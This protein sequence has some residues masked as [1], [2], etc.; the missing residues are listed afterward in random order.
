M[1]NLQASSQRQLRAFVDQLENIQGEMKDLADTF[2]EKMDE[3]KSTGFDVKIIRKILALKK[4]SKAQRDEE[5]A[6]MAVYMSALG[7]IGTPLGEYADRQDNVV[8]L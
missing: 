7:L 1:Q 2:K 5:D 6:I 4:K 3:A 8:N